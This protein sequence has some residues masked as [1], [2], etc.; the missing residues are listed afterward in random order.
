MSSTYIKDDPKDMRVYMLGGGLVLGVFLVL[1]V[2]VSRP[3]KEEFSSVTETL[4]TAP[5][6]VVTPMTMT[7]QTGELV[8]PNTGGLVLQGGT[9]NYLRVAGTATTTTTTNG[10]GT[11]ANQIQIYNAGN[12]TAS[13]DVDG[14]Y[15]KALNVTGATTIGGT[16]GVTGATSLAD[17]SI[18]GKLSSP[19]IVVS[20]S[21]KTGG[22]VFIGDIPAAQCQ[23]SIVGSYQLGLSFNNTSGTMTP[24]SSSSPIFTVDKT[25]IVSCSAVY[26]SSIY[27][28]GGTNTLSA[29][30]SGA[31]SGGSLD[32]GSGAISGGSLTVGPC[33]INGDGLKG[34]KSPQL[35]VLTSTANSQYYTPSGAKTLWIRLVG[36]GGGGGGNGG[37]GTDTLFNNFGINLNG[38]GGYG[39][40]SNTNGYVPGGN[41]SGGTICLYGGNGGL[42]PACLQLYNLGGAI[43]GGN[44]GN[45]ML[46]SGAPGSIAT[47]GTIANKYSAVLAGYGG[48]GGGGAVTYSPGGNGY[49]GVAGGGA[50][51][52]VETMI[53]NPGSYYNYI[54]GTGGNGGTS[55]YNWPGSKGG[56]GLIIIIAYF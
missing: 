50:G 29:G 34:V 30:S 4:F 49:Y 53:S 20:G 14:L 25:G 23:L 1:L 27:L 13:F 28:T 48:G 47:D 2:L 35:T 9:S 24:G 31:I 43:S 46:G 52:Y 18:T 33:T 16:L 40:S 3:G 45:S 32:V 41:S 5:V 36:A 8:V 44:G 37:N 12:L 19:N 26:C 22:I 7:V 6:P 54:C 17:T 42:P 21:Q 51:G 39:G 55:S 38:N 56:N 10:V 11:S 15:V